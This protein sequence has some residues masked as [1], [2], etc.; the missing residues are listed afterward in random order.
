M[1]SALMTG[2]RMQCSISCEGRIVA[3]G[4][5]EMMLAA[6]V[7]NYKT[8]NGSPDPEL[9]RNLGSI[10]AGVSAPLQPQPVAEQQ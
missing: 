1:Q 9:Q 7:Q 4:R 5:P 3:K 10:A 6:K 8:S 2:Y